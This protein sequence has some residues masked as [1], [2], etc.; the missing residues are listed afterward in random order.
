MKGISMSVKNGE[1]GNLQTTEEQRFQ[2]GPLSLLAGISAAV[3]AGYLMRRLRHRPVTPQQRKAPGPSGIPVLGNIVV[4]PLQ[5]SNRAAAFM[6]MH[7]TYGDVVRI[8]I[9]PRTLH[10]V[11]HPD[12][13]KYVFQD[14]NRNYTKGRGLEL[15]KNVLGEGLLTSEGEFWRQQRRLIQPLFHRRRIEEFATTM[16]RS[17]A[18]LRQRWVEGPLASGEPVDVSEAMMRLT[19][20]IVSKT[21][22]STALTAA[23]FKTVS[24]VM[25]PLLHHATSRIA[26]PFEFM[27]SWPTPANRRQEARK[28]QLDQIVYRLIAQRRQSGQDHE[29]LLGLLMSARDEET[30]ERMPDRQVRDEVMTIFLAGHETTANLLSFTWA[31]LSQHPAIR[32]RLQEEVDTVLQGRTPTMADVANLTFTNMV[33]EEALRLYPPAW[34]I[35]RQAIEDDEIGGYHIPA[36][37]G[38]LISP[39]IIHR[40]PQF[41]DNPE[42]F[43]PLRFAPE[44]S[45]GRPRY[46]F[47]PFGGGPRLCIGNRFALTEA[48]IVIAMLCQRF[49]LDLVPGALVEAEPAFTLR[50]KSSIW[51]TISHRETAPELEPV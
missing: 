5:S 13:A 50:P 24:N 11:N 1:A 17:T 36:G 18:E 40:H 19:L 20:D 9:G 12:Y 10:L 31:L 49:D 33:I 34:I 28:E 3:G 8:E 15:T 32:R 4:N 26:S 46:A 35:G 48:A 37:S 27:D 47:L 21:L 30:G 6:E 43:D 41:W 45:Q 29:D 2:L 7:R 42:G 39:Y 14:N 44:N 38:V 16:A 51:M 23:E 25:R 22:F